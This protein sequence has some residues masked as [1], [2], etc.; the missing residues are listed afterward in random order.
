MHGRLG[1]SAVEAPAGDSVGRPLASECRP[2][3][4]SE[5]P[6]SGNRVPRAER[7]RGRSASRDRSPSKPIVPA[8]ST[9]SLVAATAARAA[10]C[11][12]LATSVGLLSPAN[13]RWLATRRARQQ[14]EDPTESSFTAA[15]H[16]VR[17]IAV[18]SQIRRLCGQYGWVE[19]AHSAP[20][21]TSARSR[22]QAARLCGSAGAR[23]AIASS[24]WS[25][26]IARATTAIVI[27]W[28]GREMIST[29]SLAPS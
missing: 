28:S 8:S 17:S 7:S 20:W 24:P 6:R 13:A 12:P 22:I 5:C 27:P 19:S 11:R 15:V 1:R 25:E 29:G 10:S 16:H 4:S 9:R 3:E 21:G 26:T 2:G 14:A 18:V 23:A